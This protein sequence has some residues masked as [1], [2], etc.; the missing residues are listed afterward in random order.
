MALGCLCSCQ[1]QE[2]EEIHFAINNDGLQI[3]LNDCSSETRSLVTNSVEKTRILAGDIISLGNDGSS[4]A[5]FIIEKDICTWKSIDSPNQMTS[6]YA[7]Y[8]EI[9][10]YKVSDERI[11]EGGKEYLFGKSMGEVARGTKSVDLNFKRM[12]I[13][14]IL[15]DMNGNPYKG[16]LKIMLN[17]INKGTQELQSGIIT[18]DNATN[19][20]LIEAK[21]LSEGSITNIIPQSIDIAKSIGTTTIQCS[22]DP[23]ARAILPNN[24]ALRVYVG[25]GGIVIIDYDTPLRR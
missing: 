5:P 12:T 19:P 18:P 20:S 17:V 9:G 7:H 6:F 11:V 24:T 8:P 3:D 14:I 25:D 23:S 2:E 22:T 21:K 13:P 10:N 1:Q 16:D 15:L 4:F